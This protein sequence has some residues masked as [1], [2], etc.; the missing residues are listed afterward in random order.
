MAGGSPA[1]PPEC[2]AL[3][4]VTISVGIGLA[5][6]GRCPKE[7]RNRKL[8]A[9]DEQTALAGLVAIAVHGLTLLGD[10]WLNPGPLGDRRALHDG[11]QVASSPASEFSEAGWRRCSD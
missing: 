1:A 7:G 4:L 5:M 9:I 3:A 10:P 11:L 8:V 2:V 6:A